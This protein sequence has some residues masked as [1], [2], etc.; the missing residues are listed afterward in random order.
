MVRSKEEL[1]KPRVKRPAQLLNP[2]PQYF[3]LLSKFIKVYK[4]CRASIY[5][6]RPQSLTYSD[7][8]L[9]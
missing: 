5:K 9:G 8:P 1:A 3:S 7:I 6:D 4:S 2:I